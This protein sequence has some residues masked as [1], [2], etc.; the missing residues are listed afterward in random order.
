MIRRLILAFVIAIFL[1]WNESFVYAASDEVPSYTTLREIDKGTFNEYRYKIIEKY[2]L[3]RDTYQ[4][5]N[6][7]NTSIAGEISD[8]ADIAYK[9]LPDNLINKKYY[10]S[11]LTSLKKGIKYPN[12]STN[13]SEIIRAIEDFLDK[14]DVDEIKGT[15]QAVPTEGNAPLTVTLR[16][17]VR[18]PSGTQIPNYNYVWWIDN[19]GIREIIWK[20]ISISY[21][22]REEWKYA[23]FLD[24]VSNHKNEAG[25]TDILPFRSRTDI[26][27]KEKVASLILYVN[28]DRLRNQDELK[29]TPKEASYGL[30]FDATSSTPTSG[31]KFIKTEWDFGNGVKREYTGAPKVERIV[32]ATEGEYTVKLILK[33]NELKQIERKFVVSIHKPI[34]TI[35]SNK[36]E[37][38]I[39]TDFQFKAKPSGSDKN[40]SYEWE[41][42]DID[43][44]EV[45]LQKAGSSFNYN[46]LQKG[47]YNVKL[48]VV[49]PSGDTDIDTKIIYINS[50]APVVEF[51]YSIPKSNNPN[52]V[53][54]NATKTYDPD[55]SDEGK[56]EFS[57]LIDGERINLEDTNYN[58]STGY[59]TFDTIGEH[60]VVLEVKDPDG[61]TEVAQEKVSIESVLSL[62]V[63]AFPKV[64]QREKIVRFIVESEQWRYFE[65]DF[66]DGE[67]FWGKKTQISHTYKKSGVFDVRV[68][69][70]DAKENE[71]KQIIKVYVSD[72]DSP[73]AFI[74]ITKGNK[75]IPK[76]DESA[77]D[78]VG[79]YII[80]RVSSVK[81][82]AASSINVDWGTS[83]LTYSW[84]L[85]NNKFYTQRDINY[86]FDELGC[87]PVK[88][89]VKSDKNGKTHSQEVYMSVENLPPVLN[90][91]NVEVVNAQTDPV[92]VNISA[93]WA[94]DPDG[95]IQSYLWYYYTD[96]DNEP[97][98]F[99]STSQGSTTFVLPKITG[100][101]YFVLIMKDSNEA[102]ITS[103][104]ATGSKFFTTLAGDNINTPLI[105]FYVNDSSIIIWEDIIFTANVK[106]ILGQD[107]SKDAEFYWDFDGDGFYDKTTKDA[108]TSYSYKKSW[109]FFPRVKVK[110]KGF[111]NVRNLKID[112]ANKLEADF[113]TISIGNEIIF[114]SKSSGKIDH[115]AWELGDGEEVQ[116]KETFSHIYSDWKTTHTVILK[117]SEGT[118]LK[119]VEKEVT[120]DFKNLL[121]SKKPWL[122]IFSSPSYDENNSITLSEEGEQVFIYLGGSNWEIGAYWIDYDIEYDA[123]LNGGKDDDEN[124]KGTPSYANGDAISIPL[125][126]DKIQTIRVM[127]R[128]E[129]WVLLDSQDIRIV[130]SYI[131]DEEEINLDEIDFAWV[132]DEEKQKIEELK[133]LVEQIPDEYKAEGMR[134]IQILKEE[135]FDATQKTKTILDFET[136]LDNPSITN[137]DNIIE[138]LESL[139]VIGEN[140][141][142]EKN[143][144][145]NALKTL[146]PQS[147]MCKDGT[148][149]YNIIIGKLEDIKA[150]S[151]V[152]KNK[153]LGT[154]ILE[155]IA[156]A[157]TM[158]NQEKVDFKAILKTLVYGG[159]DNIPQD[160]VNEVVNETETGEWTTNIFV[161]IIKFL[162][163]FVGIILFILIG[164]ALVFWIL[165]K[166]KNTGGE[167]SFQDF[168]LQQTSGRVKKDKEEEDVFGEDEEEDILEQELTWKSQSS[169]FPEEDLSPNQEKISEE[170]APSWLKWVDGFENGKEEGSESQ[171]DDILQKEW[172]EDEEIPAWLQGVKVD[173]KELWGLQEEKEDWY[174]EKDENGKEENL[175]K[176]TKIEEDVPNWLKWS[177]VDESEK[178]E[179]TKEEE[180]MKEEVEEIEEEK[181]EV[182]EEE[183]DVPNWLK[184][185][186][187]DEIKEEKEEDIE[188]ITQIEEDV[189]DWLKWVDSEWETEKEEKDIENTQEEAGKEEKW[190][191]KTETEEEVSDWLK[192]EEKEEWKKEEPKEEKIQIEDQE[193]VWEWAQQ[194]QKEEKK[195]SPKKQEKVQKSDELKKEKKTETKKKE[196]LEVPDWLKVDEEKAQKK[197]DE[198]IAEKKSAKKEEEIPDWLKSEELHK[199][200]EK[201]KEEEVPDWLKL[202]DKKE[203]KNKK[204]PA[205]KS[206]KKEETKKEAQKE[207]W[208][209]KKQNGEL[210]ED[211]MD[212]P[213][214]LKDTW[215]DKK[216]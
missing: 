192:E 194:E 172:E 51:D 198:K 190:E 114:I 93:V 46:F 144:A 29:F 124:N 20:G 40:L 87:F 1:V 196:D 86:T 121:K 127:I 54:F 90:S 17:D 104:E 185:S 139:L 210:W 42:L 200:K 7:I 85:A 47:K 74:D 136:F 178:T 122:N 191:E 97:Q 9:Y 134:Y 202:D 143:I 50:R 72:S 88:L 4:I 169:P 214:W 166:I 21:T 5:D 77:C 100:N 34:A 154:E 14:T 208:N 149:C 112:V 23:I 150:S 199:P 110:H 82:S 118:K 55:Y 164:A 66:G 41:I 94:K 163:Y 102:R 68:T 89:T 168:I 91:L 159:V 73:F 63:F 35:S 130:K 30:V 179:E 157:D 65:W 61:I 175:E 48:K 215:D 197:Q 133:D 76:Y 18:D 116:G 186:W 113:D 103:D 201:K 62:D 183:S 212:V 117:V 83:G 170:W 211:G 125:N 45:I 78:W 6:E 174:E 8:L 49:E 32:Y 158:T 95:V 161:K 101:Y 105:E 213:D 33:T 92:V 37:W 67:K 165:Y 206:T 132:S 27:V 138:V 28:D 167:T 173:E 182:W 180:T 64:I 205:K 204:T 128:D 160:E 36:D 177:W 209:G 26:D 3:L 24:V 120:A 162:L 39:G 75:E 147:I 140:D 119:E 15:I 176:I 56:L 58:G 203:E 195:A 137:A 81:F 107:I 2:Y 52:T 171:E 129:A 25:Y 60:S 10:Q 216:K 151:N 69:V 115:Y 109:E 43:N 153:T 84:K 70:R 96:I 38:Y 31:T 13:Y 126:N 80:D 106:N 207:E 187:I 184:G 71:N 141:K 53:L 181:S 123:D 188:K 189:P 135:W 131:E 22:L 44:N 57:W 142:S 193:K 108:T 156:T 98:D 111:S 59:Y 79:A 152:E 19:G 12:N 99:R 145:F 16:A 155:I 11:L 146:V 148:D